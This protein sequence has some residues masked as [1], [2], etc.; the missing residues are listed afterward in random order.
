MQHV[1]IHR[2]LV[3]NL[4]LAVNQGAPALPPVSILDL[5]GIRDVVRNIPLDRLVA[6][7]GTYCG[8]LGCSSVRLTIRGL[9]EHFRDE[10]SA[11]LA[12]EPSEDVVRTYWL[13][14]RSVYAALL[15]WA[16]PHGAKRFRGGHDVRRLVILAS[17]LAGFCFIF[18][19]RRSSVVLKM[20]RG[21][22]ARIQEHLLGLDK[23]PELL[24]EHLEILFSE[25]CQPRS[26]L[27]EEC[28]LTH[29]AVPA[30]EG[31]WS[32]AHAVR[33]GDGGAFGRPCDHLG[34]LHAM[35]D[36][37]RTP[38]AALRDPEM[39]YQIFSAFPLHCIYSI[40]FLFNK[41]VVALGFE[42]YAIRAV[43]AR[44]NRAGRRA[45]PAPASSRERRA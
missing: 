34:I 40:P 43:P 29:M 35:Q 5:C 33:D 38:Q 3:G 6:R 18:T 30:S 41:I 10:T 21:L 15:A 4:L 32:V 1:Y 11:I 23:F 31:C 14:L 16:L 25:L 24:E 22:P 13:H 37:P 2:V 45:R 19:H 8:T 39:K 36:R 44:A 17:A 26:L 20:S 12:V 9:G 7:L 42:A 28:G 27:D